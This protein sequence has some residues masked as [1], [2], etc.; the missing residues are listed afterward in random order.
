MLTSPREQ[1]MLSIMDLRS[2]DTPCM[3]NVG[4][5]ISSSAVKLL[6]N[7]YGLLK[8][9]WH[10]VSFLCKPWKVLTFLGYCSIVGILS[11]FLDIISIRFNNDNYTLKNLHFIFKSY[12]SIYEA[13]RNL[14]MHDLECMTLYFMSLTCTINFINKGSFVY[15][16]AVTYDV[17]YLK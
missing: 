14:C 16:V 15:F 10:L 4:G 2:S 1:C 7:T 13:C 11:L 9:T 12:L 5:F 17:S 8:R 6:K 3:W